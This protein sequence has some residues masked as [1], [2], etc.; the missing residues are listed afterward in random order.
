V[1]ARMVRVLR[2]PLSRT[3]LQ[4]VHLMT[5]R[6]LEITTG[7]RKPALVRFYREMFRIEL[8]LIV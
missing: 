6:L 3:R 7:L 8:I 5:R 4:R 2:R 1:Q